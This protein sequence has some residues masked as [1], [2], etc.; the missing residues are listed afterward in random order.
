MLAELVRTDRHNHRQ[1]AGDSDLAEGIKILARAHQNLIW[2][3][4]RHTNR[5]RSS[6]REY[7]P[8]ALATF[9]DLADPD[10]LAVLD[11]AP[12]PAQGQALTPGRVRT[13]L[14]AG[15]RQRNIDTRAQTIVKACASSRSK[16][17]PW[18]CPRSPPPRGPRSPSWRA[19]NA[20]IADARDRAGRPF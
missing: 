13:A 10:T 19:L 17:P 18:S 2:E 5:L 1:V 11:R 20:Q 6:L 16:R 12:T 4:T 7:Y 3:R 15:G 9:A 8:A 14:R